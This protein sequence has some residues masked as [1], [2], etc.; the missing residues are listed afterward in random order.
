MFEPKVGQRLIN[1]FK[2]YCIFNSDII[3]SFN[4]LRYLVLLVLTNIAAFQ[5]LQ[6]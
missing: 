2:V 4:H 3:T 1:K 6:S 5:N